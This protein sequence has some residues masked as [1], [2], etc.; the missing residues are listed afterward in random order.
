VVDGAP[1][2]VKHGL[3]KEEAYN[4]NK[5]IEAAGGTVELK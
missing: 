4:N 1:T 2:P 3:N 5:L